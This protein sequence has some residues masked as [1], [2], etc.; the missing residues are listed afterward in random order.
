M[1][2]TLGIWGKEKERMGKAI[3]RIDRVHNIVVLLPRYRCGGC[4]M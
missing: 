4:G 3:V 2:S 1:Y